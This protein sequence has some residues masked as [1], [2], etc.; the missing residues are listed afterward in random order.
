MVGQ[1]RLW[2]TAPVQILQ[3]FSLA[4]FVKLSEYL[5]KDISSN[6][7]KVMKKSSVLRGMDTKN[8]PQ[9]CRKS[10]MRGQSS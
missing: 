2:Q 7:D 5:L 3:W 1:P 10:G 6:G 8:K 4:C 9:P